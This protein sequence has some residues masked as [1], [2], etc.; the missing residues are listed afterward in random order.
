MYQWEITDVT[1]LPEVAIHLGVQVDKRCNSLG[2]EGELHKWNNKCEWMGY[3]KQLV[4][5][6]LQVVRLMLS[7]YHLGDNST[8]LST[9]TIRSMCTLSTHR[10]HIILDGLV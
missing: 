2:F 4:V 6:S 10:G 1:H 3:R 9:N 7:Y 5:Q 8:H